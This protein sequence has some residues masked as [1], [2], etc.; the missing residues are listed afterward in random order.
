MITS[1]DVI[2]LFISWEVTITK[3]T[4]LIRRLLDPYCTLSLCHQV[5]EDRKEVCVSYL[6]RVRAHEWSAYRRERTFTEV[7]HQVELAHWAT[8]LG[9][10][11]RATLS[12]YG[13]LQQTSCVVPPCSTSFKLIFSQYQNSGPV[14][15]TW[16]PG[17]KGCYELR[18]RRIPE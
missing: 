7:S 2:T 17:P 10:N 6:E 3:S 11:A 8:H 16:K 18:S 5:T 15:L 9:M 13:R 14:D 12:S 1:I 4:G